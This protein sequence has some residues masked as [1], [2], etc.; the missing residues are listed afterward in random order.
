MG[1]ANLLPSG[2]GDNVIYD[3]VT[4]TTYC[5]TDVAS[6]EECYQ[7]K[8]S[9]I[10]QQ[11]LAMANSPLAKRQSRPTTPRGPIGWNR[12]ICHINT[13]LYGYA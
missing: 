9:I 5:N 7:R 2:E 1:E 12:T 13:V 8:N 3:V 10:P 4:R 6:P 11:A